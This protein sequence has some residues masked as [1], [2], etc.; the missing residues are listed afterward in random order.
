[1]STLVSSL[2]SEKAH[3]ALFVVRSECS[4]GSPGECSPY[5]IQVLDRTVSL[6]QVLSSSS[7]PLPLTEI[8]DR[9]RLH[10]STTQRFLRILQSYGLVC[11]RSDGKYI[12]G[13]RLQDYGEIA[14]KQFD[15]RDRATAPL[16]RL[17]GKLGEA[18]YLCIL[19]GP[20]VL[21]LDRALP[22]NNE[23]GLLKAGQSAFAP[24]T[25]A[26]RVL[27]AHSS[28]EIR[29][30]FME[31]DCLSGSGRNATHLHL[32]LDQIRKAGYAVDDETWQRGV[33][34]VAVPILNSTGYAVAALNIVG[35]S[36]RMTQE[37]I[38]GMVDH[39]MASA[40]RISQEFGC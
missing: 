25:A 32:E 3:P 33:R 6:L 23:A 39:L 1:M 20:S 10:K 29:E 30:S 21:Y 14:K 24:S 12:L 38:E 19:K 15:P 5:R 7:T 35:P 34:G 27:L 17:V 4:I 13:L 9:T 22:N 8:A 11:R 28:L 40:S 36:F 31:F 26:G 37:R 18:G 2:P 16:R